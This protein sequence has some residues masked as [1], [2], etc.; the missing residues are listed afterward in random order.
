MHNGAV[1]CNLVLQG[2]FAHFVEHSAF[3]HMKLS[4]QSETLP[5]PPPLP[6]H[7]ASQNA[8]TLCFLPVIAY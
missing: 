6:W 8:Q 5:V 2:Y 7:S 1:Q 4:S 3:S